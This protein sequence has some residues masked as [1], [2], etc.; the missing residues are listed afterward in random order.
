LRSI[1]GFPSA[2][3]PDTA[4]IQSIVTGELALAHLHDDAPARRHLQPLVAHLLA[5]E[6]HAAL[7]DQPQRLRSARREACLLEDLRDR[8]DPA[9][10]AHFRDVRGNLALTETR[11]EIRE[12]ALGVRPGVEA[13]H[14][15]LRERNLH[16]AR[17]AAGG[18]LLAPARDRGGA[19]EGE[20]LQIAPHEIVRNR[21]E[22]AEHLGRRIGD[23]D[24]VAERLRHLVDAVEPLQQR[25]GEDALR[26]LAVVLLQLAPH[27]E[28]EFLVGAAELHVGLQRDRVVPL[29]QRIEELVDRDREI[30]PVALAEVVP[31]QHPRDGVAR[32]EPDHAGRAQL[33]HPGGIERDLGALRVQDP[34]DLLAVGAGV[35]L[36]R[37]GR[38][39]RTGRVLAGRIADHSG[40][41][42]DQEDDLMA[43]RLEV[44][45]LVDEHR[46]AEVQ[47]GRGR[48]EAGLHPE[49]PP[50]LQALDQ[51]GLDQQLVDA[52]LDERE[53]VGDAPGFGHVRLSRCGKSG[54][55]SVTFLLS[56]D[57]PKGAGVVDAA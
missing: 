56:S 22:L 13:R 20:Q 23:P 6:P 4:A 14:D 41:I 24:V 1:I 8:Q 42:A 51:L 11:L 2:A 10:Q 34:E 7:L 54:L 18:D 40:E 12:R 9:R 36:D 46:M 43:E 44:A 21:H 27:Q 52:P 25:H 17:I 45:Q 31:L 39:R 32:R 15:L 35:G 33:L 47:V 37:L 19:L 3:E 53:L 49:G 5:V 16:V 30:A 38:E 28:V 26:R 55:T 57:A 29:H 50:G 48:I